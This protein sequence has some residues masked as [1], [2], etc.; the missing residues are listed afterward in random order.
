MVIQL[1]INGFKNTLDITKIL[2]PAKFL[3]NLASDA[4]FYL[5]RMTV[6]PGAFMLCRQI[7]QPVGCFDTKFLINFHQN[8][9]KP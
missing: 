2:H 7:C 8:S 5:E 6:Q 1:L 3:V 9:R 4:Q